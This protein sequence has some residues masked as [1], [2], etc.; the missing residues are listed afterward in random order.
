MTAFYKVVD[1]DGYI[2]GFGTNGSDNES[3]I[4]ESEYN[5]IIAFWQTKPT[6]PEGYGYV[7]RDVPR[8]WVMVE[9][10]VEPDEPDPEE[11]LSILLGG[12]SL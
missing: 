6:A 8:E 11:A 4:T 2:S 12:A 3:A 1:N 10:P 5:A 9:V 7:M